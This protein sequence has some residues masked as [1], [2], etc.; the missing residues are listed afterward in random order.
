MNGMPRRMGC[1]V[2]W[3]L[4]SAHLNISAWFQQPTNCG[5]DC[6]FGSH[7]NCWSG[8]GHPFTENKAAGMCQI[9][10]ELLKEGGAVVTQKLTGLLNE[11]W[12]GEWKRCIWRWIT[13]LSC[14]G[15]ILCVSSFFRG[16]RMKW[17]GSCLKSRQDSNLNALVVGR[18]SCYGTY[19]SSV[20]NFRSRWQ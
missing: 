16:C 15:K 11:C 9:P 13:L 8:E 12:Q 2:G 14:P 4:D 17:T 6:E 10:A 20:S 1:L 18:F 5:P 7:Y 3:A 19:S